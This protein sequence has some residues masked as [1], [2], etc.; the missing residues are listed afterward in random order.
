[1]LRIC[2]FIS[3]RL[4][5]K[6]NRIFSVNVFISDLITKSFCHH[7]VQLFLDIAL[8]KFVKFRIIHM[9]SEFRVIVYT[10]IS[11]EI[12]HIFFHLFFFFCHNICGAG[13]IRTPNQSIM[14]TTSVFTA[15]FGFVVWTLPSSF[16]ML[17]VK[18]LHLHLAMLGSVLP[19]QKLHRI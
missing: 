19:F 7:I 13:G 2:Q 1:M 12:L 15:P 11:A 9:R 4:L 17:S 3:S 16:R 18:S 10:G 14:L 8:E 6:I 5:I